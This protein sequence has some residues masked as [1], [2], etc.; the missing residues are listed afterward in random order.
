MIQKFS[1]LLVACLFLARLGFAQELTIEA[2]KPGGVYDIGE[3]IV[4]RVQVKDG[5]GIEKV[6]Y[7]L[8][9]GQLTEIGKGEILLKDGAGGVETKLDEPG[10]ILAEFSIAPAGKA[11]IKQLA[12]AAVAPY[13]IKPSADEPAD[14]DAFWKSK[15]DELQAVPM[16]AHLEAGESGNANV[17]YWKITL[18]NIRGSK[19]RGQ[20]S[21]PKTVD[22]L[23]ALLIV[24]W[25]GVYPLQRDWATSWS[26]Q[27][28]LTLNINAHDLPIDEP[29][30]F[31]DGQSQN[32]LKNYPAIGNNDREK[33]YFL[34]MYLS[35]YRA[36]DYLA[37]RPD[38]D[39]KNL[40]VM[41]GSQGGLQAI[42]TGGFHPKVTALLANVPAGVDHTGPLVGR[43]GGWPQWLGWGAPTTD[44]NVIETSKY[45][46][47]VNFARRVKVPALV[48][49][50][51]IDTTC[52]P[53][54]I[55]AAFNQMQGPKELLVLD[56]SGH[57]DVNKSQSAYYS[58]SGAW[59]YDLAHGKAA[60][61]REK[62]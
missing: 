15:V 38:W 21:R 60:P 18:D 31:Y 33:S 40:V 7:S 10:T 51:L 11:V 28:W 13:Q 14:F 2:L 12:G 8:R 16:N 46:D 34:R 19:I 32:A 25:A 6:S 37:S 39:G 1:W 58:R 20:L 27:G 23:P 44:K 30:E 53:E 9:K 41:G 24:Q 61:V 50:G 49:A 57:Q 36:A 45:Y 48:S 56:K 62:K 26:R 35:C 17:D 3:K 5:P 47:V 42:M 59:L 54:G 55:M 29:K 22:K 43:R 4:W 52:P